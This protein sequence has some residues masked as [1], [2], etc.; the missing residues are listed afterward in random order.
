MATNPRKSLKKGAGDR[1]IRV[2]IA[3]I[4]CSPGEYL[5]ADADGI[6]ISTEPL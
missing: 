4:D 2:T 6:V 5:Y 3:G 1:D